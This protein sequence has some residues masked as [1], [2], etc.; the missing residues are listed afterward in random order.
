MPQ[1]CKNV[2]KYEPAKNDMKV[3]LVICAD[4]VP[5]FKKINT[6][7]SDE[8]KSSTTELNKQTA[9]SCSLFTRCSF[10]S[11]SNKRDY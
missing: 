7:Y 9:C 4:I 11:N 10:N 6:C 3:T 5:L 2:I 1:K 8:E